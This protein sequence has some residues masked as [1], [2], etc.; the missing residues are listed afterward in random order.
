MSEPLHPMELYLT[1]SSKELV[2]L[3]SSHANLSVATSTNANSSSE[4]SIFYTLSN[5]ILK[6]PLLNN[7]VSNYSNDWVMLFSQ[8]FVIVEDDKLVSDLPFKGTNTIFRNR[9]A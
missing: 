3:I 6:F 2:M 4:T 8:L 1:S 7:N 5:A 9:L